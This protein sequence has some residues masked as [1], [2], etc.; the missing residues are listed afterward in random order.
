MNL[1]FFEM[2]FLKQEEFRVVLLNSNK[3]LIRHE[4]VS[5]GSLEKLPC[6]SYVYPLEKSL[7]IILFHEDIDH[8]TL[9]LKKLEKKETIES[10]LLY[11]ALSCI[12]NSSM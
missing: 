6:T 3:R 7:I 5:L 4:R 12:P 1:M 8:V 9:A 10:Y 11:N 2:Q